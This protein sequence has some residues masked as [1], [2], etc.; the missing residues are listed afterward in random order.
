LNLELQDASFDAAYVCWFLEH[1]QEPVG[2]LKEVRRTLKPGSVIYCTEVM[3]SSFFVHP[4]S[5][6]TLRYW[7]AFNDHQWLMK[8]DPFVG[9]KLGNYLLASGFQ[10]IQTTIK[11]HHYDN[12]SVKLRAEFIEY[13][14]SLLLSGAPGL[15]ESGK[16]EKET[17]EEMKRELARIKDA[18]DAVFFYAWVQA[19]AEVH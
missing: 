1:V 18:P 14:T 3:N 8:G 4:Y 5:P 17:V 15:M 13:W 6:A 12:R 10:N 2:I 16:V 19:R 11:V 9:A 7:F